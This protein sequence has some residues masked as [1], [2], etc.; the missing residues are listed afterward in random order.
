MNRFSR[1][2]HHV[3]MKD[4]KKRH[5]EE[6][7]AK[8]LEEK[9]IKEEIVQINS[10][11]EKRK[12]DWREDLNE[13]D[14]TPVDSPITN[15]TSQ[16]FHYSVPN[17][18]TGEPNTFTVSGLGG[19]ESLP[20]SV[21]VDFG[22]GES[23]PNGVNPPSYNQLALAGYAKPILI[24]RRDPEDVNPKLDASQEFTKKIDAEV[25]MN[26]RVK[27]DS[28]STKTSRT[29]KAAETFIRYLLNKLP[30]GKWNDYMGKDYVDYAI[31][32]GT[33]MLNGGVSV[34][35]TVIGSA[36]SM[37][38]DN[39]T[40]KYRINFKGLGVDDNITQFTK[41]E[42]NI[43][44]K[45]ILNYL[46]K[47]TADLIPS[48]PDW[49]K[50]LRLAVGAG[51][52]KTLAFAKAFGGGKD[53]DAFIEFSPDELFSKNPQL[54]QDY[55]KQKFGRTGEIWSPRMMG[56]PKGSD[57]KVTHNYYALY[58]KLPPRSV[59]KGSVPMNFGDHPEYDPAVIA[60][61]RSMRGSSKTQTKEPSKAVKR[62]K[63]M[64]KTRNQ[65]LSL[66]EPIVRRKK[67]RG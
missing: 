10:E 25:S 43:F 17:F 2:R 49:T 21:K 42:Y 11:Y 50:A 27:S 14:W 23:P 58:G 22:F 38:F 4:V 55:L 13:S 18:E 15:S 53:V 24:K 7:S 36:G 26:A 40:G 59:K 41:G 60:K 65:S 28:E 48:G 39:R 35:D 9:R 32:N 52:G 46:G 20:S 5:L 51:A 3:N 47:Y 30:E 1:I 34:G 62:I 56:T 64:T 45:A 6:S 19:V 54:A 44:A 61:L 12:S 63:S 29:I 31:K 67:K 16:T 33:L 57:P 37:T 8:K 66:D